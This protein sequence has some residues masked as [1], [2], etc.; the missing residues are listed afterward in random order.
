MKRDVAKWETWATMSVDECSAIT[1]AGR[2]LVYRGIRNGEI[3]SIK[4]GERRVLIPVAAIK[5]MLGN[6]E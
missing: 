1:G 3:P 4:L 2:G 6:A 5:K